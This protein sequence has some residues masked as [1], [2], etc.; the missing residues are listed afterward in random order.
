[1]QMCVF[2][3]LDVSLSVWLLW[4]IRGLVVLERENLSLYVYF[5]KFLPII[6]NSVGMHFLS[7]LSLYMFI[8]IQKTHKRLTYD[9]QYL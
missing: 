6:Q 8:A 1:M 7:H 5:S 2:E 3:S 4:S 9:I